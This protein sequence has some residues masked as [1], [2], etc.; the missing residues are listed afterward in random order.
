[1]T[2]YLVV[3][4]FIVVALLQSTLMP[5][6]AVWGVF[7]DLPLLFVV[8]W[9]L[10]SGAREGAIWGFV[11][12]LAVDFFSGAPFGAA[13]LGL[14]AAGTLSGVGQHAVFR[15]HAF[16]PSLV[17]LLATIVYGAV[18]LLVLQITGQGV[19][20]LGSLFRLV[21]PSALLNACLVPVVFV[22]TRVAH[23]RL[24]HA[25]MEF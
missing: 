8:S 6:L 1:M 5:Q 4:L 3:P 13:T 9:A 16:L 23:R 7:A 11:A 20:L 15:H 22:L 21:L 14:L 19:V 24:G 18:F 2:I 12:G 10:L 17:A 25:D